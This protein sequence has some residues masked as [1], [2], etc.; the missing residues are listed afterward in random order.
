[1]EQIKLSQEEIDSIIFNT[2]DGKYDAVLIDEYYDY[3]TGFFKELQEISLANETDEDGLPIV[4]GYLVLTSELC[5][6]EFFKDIDEAEEYFENQE[7]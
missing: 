2:D 7:N 4:V 6:P 5:V 1:M 3:K